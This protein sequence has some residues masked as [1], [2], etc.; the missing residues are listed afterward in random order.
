[1]IEKGNKDV[2]KD[3]TDFLPENFEKVG[4]PYAPIQ[5]EDSGALD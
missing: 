5:P 3:Y 4:V 2:W 1:M